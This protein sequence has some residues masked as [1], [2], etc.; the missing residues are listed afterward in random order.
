[1]P[2]REIDSPSSDGAQLVASLLA[3][4]DGLMAQIAGRDERIDELLAQVKALDARIAELEA[5]RGRPPKTPDASS[6]PSSRGKKANAEPPA[7][8]RRHKG[9]P[10]VARKLAEKPDATRGFFASQT[11]RLVKE[12]NFLSAHHSSS[13]ITPATQS[14]RR[15]FRAW[16]KSVVE[17][18]VLRQGP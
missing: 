3:R 16:K 11:T 18:L 13:P 14:R 2:D 7:V 1:M 10:G 8:K 4:I 9:R 12:M 5:H 15:H 17:S 6:L